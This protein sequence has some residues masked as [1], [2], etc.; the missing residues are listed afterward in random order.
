MASKEKSATPQKKNSGM[1]DLAQRFKAHP[2]MFVGTMIILVLV[3]VTFVFVPSAAPSMGPANDKLVFGV[4]EK[5]PIEFS[6]GSY[7]ARQRE[8]RYNLYQMYGMEVGQQENFDIMYYAFQSTVIHTAILD[9]VKKSG[10]EVPKAIIDREIRQHPNFLVDG[11]LSAARLRATSEA[12]MLA[13]RKTI[14][15]ELAKNQYISAISSLHIPQAEVDFVKSMAATRRYFQLASLS[16]DSFPQDNIRS[17][18]NENSKKFDKITLSRIR[19]ASQKEADD[20]RSTIEAG[21]ISFADAASAHSIDSLKAQGGSLGT[22]NVWELE[23]EITDEAV[24]NSVLGMPEGS[25]STPVQSGEYW[26]I[27]RVDSALAP[28]NLDDTAA[29]AEV[30]NYFKNYER[31]QIEDYVLAQANAFVAAVKD[32]SFL[33]AALDAGME[34]EEL[35]PV[36]LNY[37]GISLFSGFEDSQSTI[38]KNVSR[39]K[40]LLEAAFALPLDSISKPLIIDNNVVVITPVREEAA[41]PTALESLGNE[42]PDFVMTSGNARVSS[43]FLDSDRLE[44]RFFETYMNNFQ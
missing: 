8:Q 1:A 25:I 34:R 39:N 42:Y 17:W 6:L 20:L 30:E 24:R 26:D 35:G 10:F 44:N 7:M 9:E 5:A 38:L 32:S 11:K 15:E 14:N 43:Y 3:V 36:T 31:A 37:G 29:F 2:L 21:T 13:L 27:Y 28:V 4:W 33:D 16:L 22:R 23:F 19:V 12:D 41:D 18:A 40:E